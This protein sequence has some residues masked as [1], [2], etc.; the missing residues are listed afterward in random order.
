LTAI[1]IE[2]LSEHLTR[3]PLAGGHP[4]KAGFHI[5]H[6]RIKKGTRH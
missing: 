4:R 1:R 3:L 5:A 2:T 6:K